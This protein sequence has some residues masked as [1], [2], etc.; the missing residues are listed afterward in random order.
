MQ[1]E[2]VTDDVYVFTSD[3]Y[4]Q[5]TAGVVMTSQ[6]AVVIDTL[7]YP[8]ETRQIRRFVE[9]KLRVPVRYVV[10][11]H[12]HADHT[13]GTCFFKNADVIAHQRCRELL[14]QRGRESLEVTRSTSSDMQELSLVLPTLTFDRQM[15]IYAGNKTLRFWHTPGHS[16]DSIVCLVEEDQVLFGADTVMPVPYF[17]DGS[18][19]DF[20]TSL[21]GLQQVPV[22]TIIQGHGEVILRG[23]VEEKL[24]EDLEYLDRLSALVDQALLAAD[25]EKALAAID[26]EQ[27]GKSRVLLNGAAGQLHRQNVFVLADQRRERK[28]LA[29]QVANGRSDR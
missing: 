12:F 13:T 26:I 1:R 8:E 9:D 29:D 4:V 16:L 17:V 3:L 19:D 2:R 6:G 28:A 10:N 11:T 21:R 15:T 14:E 20:V 7:P 23:E 22:E 18:Y 25:P 5:V 27:C 24:Q